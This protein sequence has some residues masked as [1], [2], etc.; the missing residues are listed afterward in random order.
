MSRIEKLLDRYEGIASDI[1]S[2]I[3]AGNAPEK[4][5]VIFVP[6]NG[7]P[8]M[9]ERAALLYHDGFAPF[10][11][12]S[13]RFSITVGKFGGVLKEAG[14][15]NADYST[16][17]EF[18]LDVLVK[19]GVPKEAVLREDRASYTYENALNS[20][21]VLEETGI[22]VSKAI[23]CCKNYHAGRSLMYY[24]TVFPDTE[25]IVCP[26][27]VDG[28]TRENWRQSEAGIRE[29]TAE[30]ERVLVQFSLYMKK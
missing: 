26:V 28:I 29:V 9:A 27:S 14:R 15:Y 10:I 2:F 23:L 22:I 19:N 18:L 16:E 30:M 5:D 7:Y 1:E 24:Q 17:W 4:A 25:F 6:G 3:F 12:P 8:D 13:G 21:K 20:R 11:L